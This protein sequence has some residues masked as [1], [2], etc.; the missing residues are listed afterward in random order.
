MLKIVLVEDDQFLGGLIASKLT[1]VGFG[2][3]RAFTGEEGLRKVKAE[4]PELI[5][6]DILLPGLSGFDVLARIK[7]DPQI[8]E[9][10]VIMLTNL[11]QREDVAKATSLGAQDYIIKAHFTPGEIT[12]KVIA[13]VGKP[14]PA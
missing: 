10:P 5:L 4:R 3:I 6:L 13:L 1:K 8:M 2:V 7:E 9:I 14:T 12:E 11:G